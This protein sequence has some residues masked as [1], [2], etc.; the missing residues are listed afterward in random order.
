MHPPVTFDIRLMTWAAGAQRLSAVRRAVFIEEQH[1]PEALEWDDDDARS[2]HALAESRDGLPVGTARLLPD[3]HIG[4][5]AVLR[6]W[7][8]RGVGAALLR[9]LLVEAASRGDTIVR[10]NAQVQ[11]MG[12][13]E[14]FGFV[15]H[16]PLFDD[17]GIPHRGMVLILPARQ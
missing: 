14:R 4:R 11:A 1:V 15:A 16:G 13:Y 12:F 10:L 17:A 5:M 7:R 6:P 3:G 9:A 8:R 2:V